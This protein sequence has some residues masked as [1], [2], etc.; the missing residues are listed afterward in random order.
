MLQGEPTQFPTRIPQPRNMDS[1]CR[2]ETPD[3]VSQYPGI[4]GFEFWDRGSWSRILQ[5]WIPG[6][7]NPGSRILQAG[8]RIL[9]AHAFILSTQ[10]SH[11]AH[12][13][14]S[15]QCTV[16]SVET[17]VHTLLDSAVSG[18]TMLHDSGMR[19]TSPCTTQWH[20]L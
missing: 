17:P 20:T 7:R 8:S 14:L 3:C 13:V 19:M 16:H 6:S 11:V 2:I 1:G 10:L 9:N 4:L 15:E 12:C 18:N 5:S